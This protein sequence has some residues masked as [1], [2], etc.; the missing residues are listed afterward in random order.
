M[1]KI[2][3]LVI[4]AVIVAAVAI[5]GTVTVYSFLEPT[6][7]LHSPLIFEIEQ[8]QALNT[9]AARLESEGAIQSSLA[10][11]VYARLKGTSADFKVGTYRIQPEM[12]LVEVH[13]LLI[14]GRQMLLRVTI[15]EGKTL[16]EIARI[17]DEAGIVSAEEFTQAA[18]NQGILQEF[19]IPG[20][21]A[22]GFLFPDTYYFAENY[23]ALEVVRHLIVRFFENMEDI[24]PDYVLLDRSELYDAVVL[25]SIIEREYAFAEEAPIIASVFLNRLENN[26][27]LESC[28]TVE[29][30]ITEVEGEP[31]PERITD[32][33]YLRQSEYNTYLNQ[34]LPPAPIASPGSVA[35]DAVFHPGET[36]YLYFVVDP[37]NESRHHFS[38]TWEEHQ[39]ASRRYLRSRS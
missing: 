24:Y 7:N 14:S 23:P 39:R 21:T 27:K 2:I 11:R 18:M 17:M 26:Q 19:D 8:G 6:G 5:V 36:D 31:R 32:Y 22:E 20:R 33:H 34:G 9:I 13:D 25:A 3:I 4:A 28:A 30:F 12:G 16:S 1:K 38:R 15:P 37:D 35:L 29:Y 10:L